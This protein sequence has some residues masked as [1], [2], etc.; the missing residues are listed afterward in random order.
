VFSA[1][2]EEPSGHEHLR[3]SCAG[4][5]LRETPVWA[6]RPSGRLFGVL[7]EPLHAQAQLCA[8]LLAGQGH[9]GPNRMWV[10]IARR[11]AARGV[12]TL[13]ID[14]AWI[15]DSEGDASTDGGALFA[16]EY[17]DETCAVL[18]LLRARGLPPRF[19]LLGMCAGAYWSM[20]AALRD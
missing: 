14:P 20:H 15:G 11:W 19:V 1:A 4:V 12:P 3:L 16:P 9:T 18:E 8:V 17:V 10:E 5:E 2:A 7:T 6:D 13:R